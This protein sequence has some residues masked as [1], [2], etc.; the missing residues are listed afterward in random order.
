MIAHKIELRPSEKQIAYFKQACGT[1]R[2]VWNWALAEWDKQYEAGKKPSAMK[3]KKQFNAI[4]YKEFPWLEVIHRDAHSVPFTQLGKAFVGFF[5]KIAKHPKFH[6]KGQKD[7]FQVANDK[8]E[9]EDK[10][11][12]L[13]V[14]GWI[15][16][17]ECLRFEGRILSGTVSRIA[18]KWFLSVLVDAKPNLKKK[19]D[20]KRIGVDLGLKTTIVTSE[21]KILQGPKSLRKNLKRLQVKSRQLSRKVK[22]SKNREKAKLKLS[23]LHYRISCQRSDFLHKATT[24]LVCESQ[25]ISIE[26]LAVKNMMKNRKLAR[27]ISDAGFG[28]F[29]RQLEYKSDWYDTELH[30]V[31]RFFPSSKMCS[32]CGN[33]KQDLKLSDRVYKCGNCGISL[34]RDIN[35][36]INLSK[37][38]PM[39]SRE[40]KPVDNHTNLTFVGKGLEEAGTKGVYTFAH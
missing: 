28:E 19:T 22:G 21:G 4:K 33:I 5:N 14:I 3:L 16:M 17:K 7:S 1:S 27:A 38:L 26:D 30:I 15:R 12:R 36:A 18:D 2:F 39:V 40:V 6:K 37:Q 10:K 32:S 34:D 35:A 31:D 24:M 25:A 8:F 20:S 11:V 23:K 9:I 29:R 13:P